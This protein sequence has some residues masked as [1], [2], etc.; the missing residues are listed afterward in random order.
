MIFTIRLLIKIKSFSYKQGKLRLDLFSTIKPN[1]TII[2]YEFFRL[3]K[4]IIFPTGL[5]ICFL[6]PDG[7]KVNH[8]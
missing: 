1:Y 7:S 4:R 5:V 6:G 8:N 3:V 2:L